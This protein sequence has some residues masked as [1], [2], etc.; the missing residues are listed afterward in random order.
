MDQASR[1]PGPLTSGG[2]PEFLLPRPL[3][4]ARQTRM[5][6][7]SISLGAPRSSRCSTGSSPR[8]TVARRQRSSWSVSPA[9]ARHACSRSSRVAPTRGGISC[10]PG[11]R[12][13]SSETC[14][15]GC[16]ST[17]STSTCRASTHGC[18][19]VSR[20]VCGRSS[21]R[22]S[23][24]CPPWPRAARWRRSTSAT[25]AI[26]P[27]ERCWRC[28]RVAGRSSLMLDDLH[29]CDQASVELLGA[30]LH[31]PPAAPVLL[32][33]AARPRQLG[34]RLSAGLE[35]AHRAGAWLVSS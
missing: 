30:L 17:R 10:S 24:H 14:R 26:A 29:W 4:Y 19:M 8:S 1:D 23:R 18:W 7:S 34:E 35:R 13:S 3:I 32:A 31:R 15:S 5:A 16:S 25:A 11:R 27:C 20:S 12:R 22:C 9:S 21:R 2:T 33:L 28:S 6:A